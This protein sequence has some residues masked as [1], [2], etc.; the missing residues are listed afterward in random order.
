MS[1]FTIEQ[2]SRLYRIPV[3][4]WERPSTGLLIASGSGLMMSV[5]DTVPELRWCIDFDGLPKTHQ[6]DSFLTLAGRIASPIGMWFTITDPARIRNLVEREDVDVLVY[7]GNV[8][9]G[10]RREANTLGDFVAGLRHNTG[11]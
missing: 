6:L 10:T 1:V 9:F 4:D 5:M 11:R 3:I 7:G 8:R 2:A